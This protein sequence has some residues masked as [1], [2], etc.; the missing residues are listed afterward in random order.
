MKFSENDII[1]VNSAKVFIDA[2]ITRHYTIPQVA[3]HA[4]ISATKLKAGFKKLFGTSLYH[5]QHEQR[6]NKGKYLLEN[7]NKTMKEISRTLGYRYVNNFGIAFKKRFG[8]SPGTWRTI[9]F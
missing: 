8:K 1:C 7:T 3:T 4:G 9:S 2:D 5:Y 6:L